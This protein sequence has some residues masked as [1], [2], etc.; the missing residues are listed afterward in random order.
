MRLTR[1][2]LFFL[3][4]I[5]SF[6]FYRL[7]V[8]LLNDVDAQTFQ[9][10]EEV[11]VD[12]AHVMAGI[13]ESQV[14]D[15]KPD[16]KSLRSAFAN[17]QQH[18]L[19][20]TIHHHT[21]TS[22]GLHAYLTNA[23]GIVIF[24]SNNARR[25][26]QDMSRYND[27][28]LTLAG[29]YGARSSREDEK[30]PDSSILYVAAPVHS[31]GKIIAV[32]TVYKPQADVLNFIAD[33]RRDIL[34]ATILIGSG[35]ILLT[36][37]VFIWLFQ[38]VG[39]L[40]NYAQSISRGE[41]TSIPNLGKGREVNTLGKALHDMRETLEGR[42]YVENYVSSL[43]HALKSPL[44]AIKGAAELLDEHMPTEQR[45]QFLD[46]IRRET[47]RSEELV[48]N[49]LQLTELERQPHLENRRQLNLSKLCQHMVDESQPRLHEKKLTLNA[50]IQNNISLTGDAMILKLAIANLLE[51]AI[52]F[53]P[54]GGNI[55]LLLNTE[56]HKEAVLHIDDQGPGLP[57]YAMDRVFEHFYSLP[58]PG[59]D[60]KGTGLG[61]PLVHEAVKLHE[62]SAS[63][64]NL[65]NHGCRATLRLPTC[66]YSSMS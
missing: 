47:A 2:T 24:D 60:H 17:A 7:I 38:P 62:G 56:N 4:L 37:A 46:N 55:D 23:Q 61:L 43:T 51:N 29:K 54:D 58:R 32:L 1:V 26:G 53:S 18:T 48:R 16:P 34:T 5:I 25:E 44:A 3:A 27:V 41:R 31:N 64:V 66:E 50:Q 14:E 42:R 19:K 39:R 28:Q 9:A 22:I 11:M 20:A 49:L 36:G 15:G 13:I 33:R 52:A 12:T 6:G 10:T 63:L 35:I 59:S 40:T 57:H 65:P 45:K 8:Y 21:K 30:N